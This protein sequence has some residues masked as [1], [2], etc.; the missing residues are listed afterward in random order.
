MANQ[1]GPSYEY[2]DRVISRGGVSFTIDEIIEYY[3]IENHSSI[4][5][6]EK[7]NIT[8]G[9]LSRFLR[10]YNIKKPKALSYEHN[11]KTNLKLYGD[12]N[13]NNLKQAQ[14]TCL[15]KYGAEN[16]F[17]VEEFIK[18]A[19]QTKLERYNDSHYINKEQAKQTCLDRYGVTSVAKLDST[20]EH[21][22]QTFLA[23]YGVTAPMKSE[24]VKAKYNFKEIGE[25]AFETKK[26]NGTTNTSN[27]QK[28]TIKALQDFY[29]VEDVL[30]EYK[31]IRYPYHCDI[32]IKSL[33]LFIELNIFF[34]HGKH[35]FNPSSSEDQDLL[36]KWKA[37]AEYSKFFSN[38][39]R[40][41]TGLDPEKQKCA[42]IN[43][44]NYLM[45]YTEDEV[46]KFLKELK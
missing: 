36:S 24:I 33:D 22:K 28:Q 40:V 16:P 18:K 13:Y 38:A 6:A 42:K 5:T 41:W 19:E 14:K 9:Q 12:E 10:H 31:D 32:Y 29:G 7:F 35:P 21:K 25:K 20:K 46:L 27:I 2:N 17:Q 44:L 45:F 39:I 11:K 43:N 3:I 23:K 26:K 1:Y 34:T 37:K 8:Q 30:V 4:E 15:E